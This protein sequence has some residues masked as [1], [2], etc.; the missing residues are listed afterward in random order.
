MFLIGDI[1]REVDNR[2]WRGYLHPLQIIKYPL[3]LAFP[4]N[5]NLDFGL[6][7]PVLDHHYQTF[8]EAGSNVREQVLMAHKDYFL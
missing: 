3:R 6:E 5:F 4:G 8:S 2:R 7:C 1:F